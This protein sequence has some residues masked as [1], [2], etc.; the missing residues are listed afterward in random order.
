MTFSCGW[1]EASEGNSWAQACNLS[2]AQSSRW[3]GR[4]QSG[5]KALVSYSCLCMGTAPL[6]SRVGGGGR[7][8]IHLMISGQTTLEWLWRWKRHDCQNNKSFATVRTCCVPIR[9]ELSGGERINGWTQFTTLGKMCNPEY[10]QVA[11]IFFYYS[12]LDNL[13]KESWLNVWL[14]ICL[15]N[16]KPWEHRILSSLL[17]PCLSPSLSDKLKLFFRFCCC[18]VAPLCPALGDP[19]DCSMPVRLWVRMNLLLRKS[20]SWDDIL[21]NANYS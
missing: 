18:S 16:T 5:L 10:L 17:N 7:E 12:L 14:L 1:C 3:S 6:E 20:F 19:M 15:K 21:E 13:L 8:M 4:W 11:I 9:S 2:T